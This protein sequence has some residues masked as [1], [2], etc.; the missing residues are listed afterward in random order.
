MKNLG[1]D[2]TITILP[3]D[4]L[5]SLRTLII[6]L[7]GGNTIKSGNRSTKHHQ[8]LKLC[9]LKVKVLS[10]SIPKTPTFELI[11]TFYHSPRTNV[12]IDFTINQ[13]QSKI[14]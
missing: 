2:E 4:F 11:L 1:L 12:L 8:G 13:I 7:F 10:R 9:T 14:S 5:N 3:P 6:G